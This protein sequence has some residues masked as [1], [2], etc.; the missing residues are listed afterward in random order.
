MF[1]K[2][3]KGVGFIGLG[4]FE[5]THSPI[6]LCALGGL[7]VSVLGVLV[8]PTMFWAEFEIGSIAEPGKELPHIW[9][10]VRRQDKQLAVSASVVIRLTSAQKTH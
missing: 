3:G 5:D 10:Q 9:P 2:I 1:R 4:H 6:I 7:C 8:P